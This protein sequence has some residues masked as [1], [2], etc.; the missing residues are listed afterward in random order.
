MPLYRFYRLPRS[1]RDQPV[2]R[3]FYKDSVAMRWA[4]RQA[5]ADGVEVW[6]GVR[7]VARLHGGAA[8]DASSALVQTVQGGG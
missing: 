5:D 1:D 3:T 2:E 4:F 8:P 6:Q 7:F